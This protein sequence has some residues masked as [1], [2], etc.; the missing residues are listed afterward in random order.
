V[1]LG[2]L[3]E[4]EYLIVHRGARGQSFVYE[5]VYDGKGRDGAPF[6]SGL[7]D[8]GEPGRASAAEREDTTTVTTLG[9]D[10]SEFVGSLG[11]QTGVKPGGLLGADRATERHENG[12]NGDRVGADASGTHI[13]E[14]STAEVVAMPSRARRAAVR[15]AA[16]GA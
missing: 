10:E 6:V 11:A 16:R 1:H 14:T 3:V 9:G 7:I 2:R 15:A 8:A 12:S 13:R 4:L 5:L